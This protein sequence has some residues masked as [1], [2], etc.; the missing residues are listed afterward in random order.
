MALTDRLGWLCRSRAL[1]HP[2]RPLGSCALPLPGLCVANIQRLTLLDG[3]WGL[4]LRVAVGGVS[5]VPISFARLD[6]SEQS[7][8][9]GG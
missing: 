1:L 7:I 5:E 2:G 8:F 4:L 9:R 6:L 3:S